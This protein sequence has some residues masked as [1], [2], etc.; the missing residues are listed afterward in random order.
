MLFYP[1][2]S[3]I[4]ASGTWAQATERSMRPYVGDLSEGSPLVRV[5][6]NAS[7][8]M[9]SSLRCDC[10]PLPRLH[11][12]HP[13]RGHGAIAY[14]RQ[15]GR[16]IAFIP[17]CRPMPQDTG[18][19]TLDANLALDCLLTPENTISL[20]RCLSAGIQSIEQRMNNPEYETNSPT[21]A[22]RFQTRPHHRWAVR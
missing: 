15:E 9:R 11:E 21:T 18:M 1:R 13:E 3:E 19:D 22:S 14:M 7:P 17:K 5:H 6:S 16:G 12:S 10:G 4:F 8:A 20:L 2:P